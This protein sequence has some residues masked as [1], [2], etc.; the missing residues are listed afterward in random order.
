VRFVN[1]RFSAKCKTIYHEESLKTGKKYDEWVYPDIVGFTLISEE[2]DS[3][4]VHLAQS[5][6]VTTARLYSFELKV[7]LDFTTLRAKFFQ[8]VSNSSWAHEGYLV[9]AKIAPEKDFQDALKRLSQSF[10]IGVIQLNLQEP[11]ESEIL[12]PART[13][14]KPDWETMNYISGR[15][16]GF[17]TFVGCVQNSIKINGMAVKEFDELLDD[18]KL[19]ECLKK[20]T[21]KPNLV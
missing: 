19:S 6:G 8:A 4:V 7:S 11:D 15:N 21:T 9:T 1:T 12:Y 5:A 2:W 17:A 14:Q 3:A 16:K 18:T 20:F 10:G 13:N